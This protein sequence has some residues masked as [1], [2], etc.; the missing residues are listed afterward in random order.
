MLEEV[1]MTRHA[2]GPEP[3]RQGQDV[4]GGPDPGEWEHELGGPA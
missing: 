1:T 3:A 4:L 2:S